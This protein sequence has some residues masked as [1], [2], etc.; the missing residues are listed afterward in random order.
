MHERK[1]GEFTLFFINIK[2][3]EPETDYFSFNWAE[4]SVLPPVAKFPPHSNDAL[5]LFLLK[6]VKFPKK[7][8]AQKIERDEKKLENSHSSQ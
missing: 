3:I 4:V 2:V 8:E 7:D 5:S 1:K 6:R